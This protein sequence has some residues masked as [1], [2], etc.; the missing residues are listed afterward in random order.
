M[1]HIAEIYLMKAKYLNREK[2]I[3]LIFL[4]LFGVFSL[5]TIVPYYIFDQDQITSI[6]YADFAEGETEK[7]KEGKEDIRISLDVDKIMNENSKAILSQSIKN[8][9]LLDHEIKWESLFREVLTP[10][11]DFQ[12]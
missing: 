4:G 10:P 2:I 12:S 1:Q 9:T 8:Q 3:R 5:N 6:K 7:E 11:P